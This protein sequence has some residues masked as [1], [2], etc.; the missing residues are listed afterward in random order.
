MKEENQTCLLILQWAHVKC[1]LTQLK[2]WTCLWKVSMQTYANVNT[3]NI[4]NKHF[5][6]ILVCCGFLLLLGSC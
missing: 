3:I 6:P 5:E 4:P 2:I 1:P